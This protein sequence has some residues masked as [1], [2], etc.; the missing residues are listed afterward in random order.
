MSFL[1]SLFLSGRDCYECG[2]RCTGTPY[3]ILTAI[4]QSWSFTVSIVRGD[5]HGNPTLQS[6]DATRE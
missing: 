4:A 1:S 2:S 6:F 3:P 5:D